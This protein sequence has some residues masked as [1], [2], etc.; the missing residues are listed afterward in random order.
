MRLFEDLSVGLALPPCARVV[1]WEDVEAY[2]AA[3]GDDNP[4]H[5]SAEVAFAAGF[6]GII[7]HGM[8]TM[9]HLTQCLVDWLGGARPISRISAGFR[10]PVFLGDTIV[11]GGAVRAVDPALRTASFELWVT[12]DRHGTTEFPIKRGSAELTFPR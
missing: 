1:T 3:S 5:R 7:A 8:F 6:E 9:G 4:L 12:V 10:A 11:A 2:A